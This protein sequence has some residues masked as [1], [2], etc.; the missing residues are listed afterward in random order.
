MNEV[1]IAIIVYISI[2]ILLSLLITYMF[3]NEDVLKHISTFDRSDIEGFHKL[4]KQ[5]DNSSMMTFTILVVITPM[6]FT[7]DVVK[8]LL[9]GVVFVYNSVSRMLK[10]LVK[11]KK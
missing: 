10:N 4:K 6:L 11:G 5:Y 7:Y 2:G 1:L 9:S 8:M 3:K